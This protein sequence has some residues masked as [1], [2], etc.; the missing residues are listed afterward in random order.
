MRLSSVLSEAGRDIRSG[1][2]RFATFALLLAATTG[3]AGAADVGTVA[4]LT[5]D[6][7][8]YVASGA[9]TR[10]AA[11][12][13]GIDGAA[14]DALAGHGDV[15][16]A[17]ALRPGPGLALTALPGATL[18]TFEVTPGLAALIADSDGRA[19]AWLSPTL[20]ERLG[21]AAGT[22]S[23]HH[24]ARCPSRGSSC[25]RTTGATAASR[26]PCCCPATHH[27]RSTSAGPV[28]GRR[29]AAPTTS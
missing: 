17:G 24:R 21:A 3:I 9:A 19:G 7:S 14:C 28:P 12:E 6:A 13:G 1:T 16:A 18:S 27:A 8:A 22:C 23:A 20:A 4:S 5:R 25:T 15:L 29:A 11:R 26:P 2:T 10:T